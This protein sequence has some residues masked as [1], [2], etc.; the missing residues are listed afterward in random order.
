MMHP[1]NF[2]V[3]KYVLL[4]ERVLLDNWQRENQLIKSPRY[5]ILR[6][7]IACL[8]GN[9]LESRVVE[10]NQTISKPWEDCQGAR[11]EQKD[12]KG[13]VIG[14]C[15]VIYTQISLAFIIKRRAI[16]RL[17]K[18]KKFEKYREGGVKT[19]K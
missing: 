1:Y 11:I 17:H 7:Y 13:V 6:R 15:N 16:V 9:V 5:F 10:G 18:V 4:D 19:G 14:P 8:H 12:H 2:P 3:L